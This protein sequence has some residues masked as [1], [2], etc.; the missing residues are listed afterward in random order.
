MISVTA[1][2]PAP[3]AH[4]TGPRVLTVATIQADLDARRLWVDGTHVPLSG[5]P[6]DVLA[7]LMDNAGRVVSIVELRDLIG[8]RTRTPDSANVRTYVKQ[9]RRSLTAHPAAFGRL[10]TVRGA[11]YA[12]DLDPDPIAQ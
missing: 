8:M 2:G 1:S 10:R 11:G 5:R 4:T 9:L 3:G 6:F 12:F 7:A